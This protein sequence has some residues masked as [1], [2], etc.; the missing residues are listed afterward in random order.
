MSAVGAGPPE[1]AERK[2][3]PGSEASE[4]GREEAEVE[5]DAEAGAEGVAAARDD[6]FDVPAPDPPFPPLLAIAPASRSGPKV[7]D[8]NAAVSGHRASP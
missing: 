8:T 6:D 3:P 4:E 1:W 2:P 7:L 5:A